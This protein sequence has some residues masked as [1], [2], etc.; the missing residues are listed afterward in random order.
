MRSVF[1]CLCAAALIAGVAVL[2]NGRVEAQ[3]ET[4]AAGPI[5]I[6]NTGADVR[7]AWS[8]AD[9][10]NAQAMD[11]RAAVDPSAANE[12]VSTGV[13]VSASAGAPSLNLSPNYSNMLYDPEDAAA[14]SLAPLLEAPAAFG[15]SGLRFSSAR[16]TPSTTATDSSNLPRRTGKLFF[17]NQAGTSF[18]CSASVIR[19]RLIATAGHCVHSG[20]AAGFHKDWIFVPAFRS[21]AAPYGSWTWTYAIV[22]ATWAG[23]GGGVPN[24]ADYALIELADK[25]TPAAPLRIG[26]NV[27]GFLGYATLS[28]LGNHAHMLGYPCN[29]DSCQI[30]HQV[31]AGSGPANGNNTV[32]YG[33]DARGGSS[34][35]PWVQNYGDAYACSSG[36]VASLAGRN[37][38]I[39]V[40]SYGPV[41]T[42]P[43]YQ[44]ASILDSRFA[45]A[46]NSLI[47]IACAH[48][49]GNCS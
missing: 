48:K 10:A 21:G 9:F 14:P 26:A 17:K 47:T 20:T 33:S 45:G 39:A 42:T 41:S 40:T 11:L 12:A 24:A 18:V 28:L 25:G 38:M 27:T 31:S 8:A 16:N 30:Q 44:G 2:L 19:H 34:G 37:Q 1:K 23:G 4:T 22:T 5:S 46:A 3:V 29:L 13:P 15:T 43:L 6:T 35:G 49:A 7:A 32:I 36:C